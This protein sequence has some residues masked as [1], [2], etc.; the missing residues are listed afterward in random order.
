MHV[1]LTY[2]IESN[3]K[4]LFH[5]GRSKKE[6]KQ[7]L[8]A[9]PYIYHHNTLKKYLN[10]CINFVQWLKKK[11]P[12]KI[13]T[14]GR[15]TEKQVADY[16][17]HLIA[18]D[19]SPYTIKQVAAAIA[20]LGDAIGRPGWRTV[21]NRET[22]SVKRTRKSRAYASNAQK[23]IDKVV[24]EDIQLILALAAELGLRISEALN[25]RGEHLEGSVLRVKGKGGLVRFV[26]VPTK[27]LE[28]LSALVEQKPTGKLFH[29][30]ASTVQ[31]VLR[32]TCAKLNIP[33]KGV[34]GLRHDF[35]RNRYAELRQEGLSQE[36]SKQTVSNEL[37]HSRLEITDAYLMAVRGQNYGN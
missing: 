24:Q 29:R 26:D 14:L 34:H 7:F 28:K 5:P 31:R 11:H 13:A 32:Q 4:K 36:D 16:L 37:G 8:G 21:V 22:Q 30:D 6:D 35:A 19:Y 2:Q 9:T 10:A 15:I 23:I 3:L 20:K 27:I 12:G 33:C 25:V 18:S 17:Q 1:G